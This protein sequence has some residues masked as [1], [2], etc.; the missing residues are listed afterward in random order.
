MSENITYQKALGIIEEAEKTFGK[1]DPERCA[2]LK[3]C[4]GII[5]DMIRLGEIITEDDPVDFDIKKNGTVI[6]LECHEVIVEGNADGFA[7]LTNACERVEFSVS[8]SGWLSVR[9]VLPSL[10]K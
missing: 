10:W 5:D 2:V 6:M 7:E 3:N 9:A 8:P 4:C 1:A